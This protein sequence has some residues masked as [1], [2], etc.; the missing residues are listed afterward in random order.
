MN[1][2]KSGQFYGEKDQMTSFD[3]FIATE[4]KCDYTVTDWH[5][6]EKPYF[7]FATYGGFSETT[8][9]ETYSCPPGTLI[10]HNAQEPHYNV[11]PPG[12]SRCFQL[13][14]TGHWFA[15]FEIDLGQLPFNRK[16]THPGIKLL[17]YNIYKE[18]KLTDDTSNLTIDAL[19]LETFETLRGVGKFRA[20]TNPRWV[21]KIDEILH[22]DFSQPLSLK[23]LSD[24]LNLHF[25]HLSRDFPRYF[26]CNFSH[27][28]RKI[29]IEKSFD[30]LRNKDL[31]LT[32]IALTCGFADQ[33]HFIRCF[34][35]FNAITPKKFRQIIS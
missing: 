26:R 34:K 1:S 6:H 29:R 30:L 8:R 32:E 13:E 18:S 14:L 31:S 10:F 20:E 16:I 2:F 5:Y 27:Y 28:I 9:H 17:F 35:E 15:K 4:T 23:K 3:G 11:K 22:D 12:I 25:A 19:L 33:S 24:E 7:S 21:K